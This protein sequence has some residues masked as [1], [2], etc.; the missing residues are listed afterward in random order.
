M[1]YVGI[2]ENGTDSSHYGPARG[3][4]AIIPTASGVSNY[5]IF[6][7]AYEAGVTALLLHNVYIHEN[8]GYPPIS[9]GSR[10]PDGWPDPDYPDIPFIMLSKDAGDMILATPN[11]KLRLHVDVDIGIRIVHVV[12][13]E[14]PGQGD[15]DELVVIGS[16]H[17][18]VYISQGAIDNGSG[19]TTVIE[20]A[21]QLAEAEVERTIRFVTYGG[22]EDG[23]FGSF[24]YV[25][26]HEEELKRDCVAVLNFDMPHV[27]LQRGNQGW[28]TPDD[29]DRFGVF[30]AIIDQ[31]YEARP[32]LNERF[33]YSVTLL[34]APTEVGSDSLP[35]ARLGIE[36]VNFWG[37]G[38]WEYHTYYE[39]IE[40]FTPE[41]LEMAVLAG[42][43]AAM[44]MA[45]HG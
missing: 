15:T 30:E 10:Q 4:V 8:I 33:N 21:H 13:G 17:D 1:E 44:W 22:E 11:A 16:H 2:N 20:L 40:H 29:R 27:N 45:D 9:K 42:G 37:S 18:G 36:T 31:V 38:A 23:L 3:M 35:Y 7:K 28:I 6:D 26:A 24:A 34:E 19:T 43:S 12:V 25:N 39:N 41:G 32:D 14:V 5:Q